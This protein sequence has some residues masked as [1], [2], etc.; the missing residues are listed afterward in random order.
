MRIY[1]VDD[2]PTA[3]LF[4]RKK[5]VE[6]GHEVGQAN[7]GREAWKH[8]Q[9]NPESLVITDWMMPE[10]SGLDLCRQIRARPALPYT[11]VILMTVKYLRKDQL[12]GLQAG[13]DDFLTKPV[14]TVEL[15]T[16]LDKARRILTAQ[17]E[18]Q[19]RLKEVE[20]LR[21]ELEEKARFLN[22]SI[23]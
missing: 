18:L 7:N 11:Y 5:L 4:L 10:M 16:A 14:D 12:E 21:A 15:V 9:T 23:P 20:T 1:I 6:L 17:V 22:L 19:K 8:L 2:S 3:A 13:A